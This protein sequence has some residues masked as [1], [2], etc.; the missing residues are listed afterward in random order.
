MSEPTVKES[1]LLRAVAIVFVASFAM[2]PMLLFGCSP[3]WARWDASQANAFFKQGETSDA[4][5]Q[6]RDAIRK[7]PRDGVIKLTLA[8]R[9]I[10]LDQPQES[11]VLCAEVLDVYPDSIHAMQV[12]SRAQQRSGDFAAALATELEIDEWLQAYRRDSSRLNA[13]AYARVLAN[14]DLP[15]AKEGIETAI[16]NYNRALGWSA[17]SNAPLHFQVKAT[18]LA[19][20]VSRSCGM[21]N[22]SLQVL[23]HEIAFYRATADG[24]RDVLTG[25]V[26]DQAST[27]FPLRKDKSL[28]ERRRELRFAETQLATLLS[29]RALLLQD[30]GESEPCRTDRLEVQ[31]IGYQSSQVV[32]GFPDDKA[33]LLSLGGLGGILDTRGFVCGML[34]WREGLSA[35]SGIDRNRFSSHGDALRDMNVAVLCN[36]VSQ[37]SFDCSLRNVVE[38][39]F[40]R[41][42]ELDQLKKEEAVLRY[43]RMLIHQRHGDQELVAA[44]E[45]RI[46][47]LGEEPG[48]DLF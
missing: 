34:P 30:L 19:S 23:D 35:E 29:C 24:A 3:E 20:L 27:A 25:L 16:A 37:A 5:Y 11:L 31:A 42:R 43:H 2:L 48:P 13:I 32:A 47:E 21:Q 40:D 6:L 1:R 26:Y 4:L 38:L 46:R 41:D 12:K 28:R 10:E 39:S 18:V 7:S 36:R 17:S 33:A 15:L 9:L 44:D 8:E 14:K 22:E 45:K